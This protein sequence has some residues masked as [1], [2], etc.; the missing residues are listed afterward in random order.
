MNRR[1][2]AASAARVGEARER[3]LDT[4]YELFR[5]HG[6]QAVGVNRISEEAGVGKRTLYRHFRSKAELVVAVL[7]L[8]EQRWT[9]DWLEREIEQRGSDP[10][11][12]LLAVFDVFDEWFGRSDFESCMF[13]DSLI[14][15]HDRRS[16]IGSAS[17][18]HI[19]NVRGFIRGLAEAA[20]MRD[21]EGFARRWQ[22]LMAGSIVLATRGDEHAAP[23][24]RDV[25]VLLLERERA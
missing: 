13:I 5:R 18:A 12:R 4:A 10:E 9:V 1:S 14:E 24:A 2:H 22:I 15:S 7:A 16:T 8:H 11:A 6:F 25:A 3:I 21:P 17:A 20:G 23:S 19:E